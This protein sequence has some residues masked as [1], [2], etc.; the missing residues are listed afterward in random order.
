MFGPGLGE[1]CVIHIGNGDWI[2]I[3]SC[4]DSE[5]KRPAALNYLDE[6]GVDYSNKV[7]LLIVTHFHDDHIRG[8]S[9]IAEKCTNATLCTSAAFHS[10][11]F[12]T[13]LAVYNKSSSPV[14]SGVLELYKILKLCRDEGRS[15]KHAL[16]DRIIYE[17]SGA[18]WQTSI[19]S[20]APSDEQLRRS[21]ASASDLIPERNESRRRMPN[22]GL[23]HYSVVINVEAE[24]TSL[25]LGG[26]LEETSRSDCG[27][28]AVVD[29]HDSARFPKSCVFK[30]PHHGSENG[31]NEHVWSRMLVSNC[32][33]ILTPFGKG[34]K[35]LP[36][37]DDIRRITSKTENAYVTAPRSVARSK[38]V[39]P[40]AVERSV[41][42]V[43][44]R[45]RT[46]TWN[47]G[48]I[49]LRKYAEKS[50]R[51]WQIELYNGA[52]QLRTGSEV[53]N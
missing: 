3:D 12:R 53:A 10:E 4:I 25:L 13:V 38:R 43:A 9:E 34:K 48:H 45:L 46:V 50:D 36:S 14:G 17:R 7:I 18:G 51:S 1:C 31:H 52:Q 28:K 47:T 15:L 23:N 49:R 8:I 39:R 32:W 16:V 19:R 21:L 30:V 44:G 27:W 29:A 11:E 42:E 2:I 22:D 20:L 37:P 40:S 6:I 41:R 33:A 26:D 5:S 35:K 24:G